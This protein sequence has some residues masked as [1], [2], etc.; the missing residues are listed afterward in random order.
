MLVGIVRLQ[1]V[2]G[3]QEPRGQHSFESIDVQLIPGHSIETL[4][5]Q[6]R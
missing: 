3:D 6:C 4:L 2:G 5:P 1:R